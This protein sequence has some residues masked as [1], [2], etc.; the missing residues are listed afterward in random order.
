MDEII[1][2]AT[3][4]AVA[5]IQPVYCARSQGRISAERLP[6]RLQHWRQVM[7]SACE[8]CGR[9]RLPELLD[10]QDLAHWLAELPAEG[11]HMVLN[12]DEGNSLLEI[13]PSATSPVSILVGPEGGFTHQETE[14]MHYAGLRQVRLAHHTLRSETAAT[15]A[16]AVAEALAIQSR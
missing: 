1:Q 3:E 14:A 4:L 16:L 5:R 7:I 11:V 10:I 8:Q 6:R 15:S 12:A 2:K 13:L 9:N